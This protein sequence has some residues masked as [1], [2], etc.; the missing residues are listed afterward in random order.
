[1]AEQQSEDLINDDFGMV[2]GESLPSKAHPIMSI[3]MP[4][5]NVGFHS[6]RPRSNNPTKR[7]PSNQFLL[8]FFGKFCIQ[9]ASIRHSLWYHACQRPDRRWRELVQ[10]Q[11]PTSPY[12]I[13]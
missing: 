1:M 12:L 2:F 13:S 8:N 9:I 11:W 3:A 6:S 5:E 10:R 7:V 4:V